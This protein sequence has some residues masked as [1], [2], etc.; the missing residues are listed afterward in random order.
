MF[1]RSV[2]RLF[3]APAPAP[4]KQPGGRIQPIG[5]NLNQSVKKQ[6]NHLEVLERIKKQRKEQKNNRNQVDPII[7]K[8]Y[9]ELEEEGF[10]EP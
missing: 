2:S 5:V 9:E 3:C 10:F 4:R 1:K 8:A 7:A 6:L